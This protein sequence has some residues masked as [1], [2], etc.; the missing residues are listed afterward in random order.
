[1]ARL[2]AAS[3]LLL[4]VVARAVSA[5]DHA[6]SD[7]LKRVVELGSPVLVACESRCGPRAMPQVLSAD[8]NVV[9]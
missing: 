8:H 3:L 2:H 9:I 1:M 4:L 5:W 7:E 6:P